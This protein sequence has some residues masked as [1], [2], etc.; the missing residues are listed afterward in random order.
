M[1]RF[2][3]WSVWG[4]SIA[5]I[6]TGALLF[7]MEY[8]LEP[9]D[10]WAVINHPLQPWVLK[11]HIISAPLLVFALG[12]IAIRHIWRHFR[13]NARWGRKSGI[14]TGL[15]TAPMI[16]TGYLIQAITHAGWL[17]TIAISHI[18]LGFVFAAGLALHQLF[19]SRRKNG[20]GIGNGSGRSAQREPGWRAAEPVAEGAG[21]V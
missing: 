4:T 19:I 10:P 3:R 15:V 21:V 12:L 5:V 7:W 8:F 2:E 17:A 6:I 13:A 1:S 20:N 16:L 14:I 9:V 18:V 11:A